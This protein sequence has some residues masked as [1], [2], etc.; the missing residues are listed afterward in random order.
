MTVIEYVT[1]EVRRQGHNVKALDG[2]QRVGWMLDAWSYAIRNLA[3][4]PV[5]QDTIDIGKLV[6]R[7]VNAA[8]IR[9]HNI[10]V[11]NKPCP[12]PEQL[13]RLLVTLFEQRDVLSPIEFYK[14]FEEIH[15]FMDGNGRTG[16]VLLNWLSGTLLMPFFPPPDLWGHPIRN[17]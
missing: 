9:N 3:R 5:V 2:I 12:Q 13:N 10:Y 11:G 6:E 14:G 8:G 15:P 4:R 17:P 1:E 7:N 16:K